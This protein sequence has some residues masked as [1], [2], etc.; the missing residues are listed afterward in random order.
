[1]RV[2]LFWLRRLA[3]GAVNSGGLWLKKGNRQHLLLNILTCCCLKS[4]PPGQSLHPPRTHQHDVHTPLNLNLP[5]FLSPMLDKYSSHPPLFC[6][7]SPFMA[8]RSVIG[9]LAEATKPSCPASRHGMP[10]AVQL[11]LQGLFQVLFAPSGRPSFLAFTVIISAW[12]LRCIHLLTYKCCQSCSWVQITSGLPPNP[13]HLLRPSYTATQR[14]KSAKCHRPVD[15]SPGMICYR[16]V[17]MG[18]IF[19]YYHNVLGVG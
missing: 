16:L 1:M 18:Y 19:R 15:G 14:W 11:F 3:I 7:A 13:M 8:S 5:N 10:I 4:L 17:R 6:S 9:P 2:G 12:S